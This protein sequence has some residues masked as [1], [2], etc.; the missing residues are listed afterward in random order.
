MSFIMGRLLKIKVVP[1]SKKEEIIEGERLTVKVKEPAER[2]L[3]NKAVVRLVSRHFAS[4][5][6]IVAGGRRPN[7]T[8]EIY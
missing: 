8:I 2:G 6:R 4:R 5:V 7:K 3:A 1:D